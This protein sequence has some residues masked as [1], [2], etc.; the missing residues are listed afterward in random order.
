MFTKQKVNFSPTNQI[1]HL[2]VG[3]NTIVL[4]MAN[5]VLLRINL[6]APD[7]LEEVKLTSKLLNLFMDPTGSYTLAILEGNEIIYLQPGSS[8][9]KVLH[10]LRGNFITSMCWTPM[11]VVMFG[12]AKG[13]IVETEIQQDSNPYIKQVPTASWKS[14]NNNNMIED[15]VTL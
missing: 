15:S 6:N 9:T 13:D 5:N 10:K 8:K 12:T 7:V 3:G 1:T 14:S 4:A 11:G 2:V